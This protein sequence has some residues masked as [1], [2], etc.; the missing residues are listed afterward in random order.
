M[1]KIIS[2]LHVLVKVNLASVADK[3]SDLTTVSFSLV[4]EFNEN[5]ELVDDPPPGNN[6]RTYALHMWFPHHKFMIFWLTWVI[7]T[8]VGHILCGEF[9]GSFR[10]SSGNILL[11]NSID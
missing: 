6:S 5:S 3:T 4:S 10:L 7:F 9:C 1:G 2:T 11:P 8:P